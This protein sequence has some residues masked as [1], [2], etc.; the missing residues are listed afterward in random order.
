MWHALPAAPQLSLLRR[1][2]YTRPGFLSDRGAF[3]TPN[4]PFRLC[5]HARAYRESERA[6]RYFIAHCD[7]RRSRR[8]LLVRISNNSPMTRKPAKTFRG[9]RPPR[10]RLVSSRS[11][12]RRRRRRRRF[13]LATTRLA[14]D[15]TCTRVGLLRPPLCL[16]RLLSSDSAAIL[17]L[18]ANTSDRNAQPRVRLLNRSEM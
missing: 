16:L 18:C 3:T 1:P 17:E 13:A 2:L 12:H 4:E 14:R 15:I 6:R 8:R 9:K 11:F 10:R 5:V 7:G